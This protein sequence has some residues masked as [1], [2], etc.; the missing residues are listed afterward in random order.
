MARPA[1]PAVS[2]K[3]AMN[4]AQNAR[5]MLAGETVHLAER[6]YPISRDYGTNSSHQFHPLTKYFLAQGSD[7]MLYFAHPSSS[8][9]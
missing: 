6:V 9:D 8:V 5:K 4:S 2:R 3:H 1:R 7:D